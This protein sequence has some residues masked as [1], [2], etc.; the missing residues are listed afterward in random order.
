MTQVGIVIA[1]AVAAAIT[2]GCGMASTTVA[3]KGITAQAT[4]TLTPAVP[5]PGKSVTG[6]ASYRDGALEF[7]VLDTSRASHVGDPSNPGLSMN[8]KGVFLVATLS[9]RN[10]GNAPLT[11][12]DRD[13]TLIDNRGNTFV[14]SMAAD[15]YANPDVHSTRI[16]PGEDLTVRIVFDVPG[17]TVP[18]KLLLRQSSSSRGVAVA[19]Q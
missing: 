4:E 14:P 9:I 19:L 10:V 13:Q 15:I 7:V 17:D 16:N 18:T 2:A 3:G 8:A 1:V 12:F 11:V 6:T 5:R